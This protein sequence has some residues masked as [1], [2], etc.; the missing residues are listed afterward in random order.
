MATLLQDLRYGLRMLAKDRGF[1]AVAVLTLALGIGANTAIFGVVNSV[2]LKSLPFPYQDPERLVSVASGDL[3][4]GFG[5]NISLGDFEEWKTRN[6]VFERMAVFEGAWFTLAGDEPQR[7]RG[8][9]ISADWLPTLGIQPTLGRNFEAG[10]EQ[11]GRDAVVILSNDCWRRRFN[12]DPNIV[13]KRL[14]LNDRSYTVVGSCDRASN[15]MTAK[16]LRLS[17]LDQPQPTTPRVP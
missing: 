15:S 10:E 8:D 7:I 16:S 4:S 2:L 1:T 13:G 11:A 3:G 6:H 9:F 5:D 12:A 14:T 17:S